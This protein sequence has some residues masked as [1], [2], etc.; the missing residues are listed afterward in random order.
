MTLTDYILGEK[1]MEAKRLLRYSDKPIGSIAYYLGFSS[2][3]HF[4]NVFK[5]YAECSPNEYR[6]KH[7]K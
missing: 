3:S 1:V 5:K 6:K 7:Q 4:A 2:Q